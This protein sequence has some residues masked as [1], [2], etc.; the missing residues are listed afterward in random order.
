MV[1]H[2]EHARENLVV[3]MEGLQRLG[4][5]ET[6]L[7][8]QWKDQIQSQSHPLPSKC[9]STNFDGGTFLIMVSNSNQEKYG[10]SICLQP[11]LSHG[12]S[13]HSSC[14]YRKAQKGYRIIFQSSWRRA[15]EP[16]GSA[17][18][19]QG[20]I[21]WISTKDSKRHVNPS[22]KESGNSKCAQA[23]SVRSIPE[24]FAAS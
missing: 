17:A 14:N 23:S 11:S 13:V 21:R 6:Y 12:I 2:F 10:H 18:R 1:K 3:A 16:G 8:E 7:R 20:D 4:L 24:H 5:E 15:P 22:A 9:H 19:T